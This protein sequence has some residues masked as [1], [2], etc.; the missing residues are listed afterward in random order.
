[1]DDQ[2]PFKKR[3]I[4]Q[5]NQMDWENMHEKVEGV[6]GEDF[7]SDIMKVVPRR[8]PNIDFFETASEG[9][10]VV[11]LPGL[12]SQN[13]VKVNVSGNQVILDGRIPYPYPVEKEQ[14]TLNE[15]Y[16]GKFKRTIPMS[17]SFSPE[18]I[19]ASYKNGLLVL[20]VPK[21]HREKHVDISFD[22]E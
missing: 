11:E 6:L 5:G 12:E 9:V 21:V 7:W 18:Q 13:H 3:V 17:F 14:L 10:I 22:S 19:S 1:M 4:N 8:G 20:K 2:K 16:C 15:R